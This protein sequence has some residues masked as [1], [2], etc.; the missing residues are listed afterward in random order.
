MS[1]QAD[2]LQKKPVVNFARIQTITKYAHN[3]LIPL[4]VNSQGQGDAVVK[5]PAGI[6][7]KKILVNVDTGESLTTILQKCA[8]KLQDVLGPTTLAPVQ[9]LEG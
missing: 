1:V 7:V 5:H 8:I 3:I 6:I 4:M 9:V 2:A